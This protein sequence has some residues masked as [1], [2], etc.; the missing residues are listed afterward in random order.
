MKAKT[1][2]ILL[3]CKS[4]PW[5][6]KGGI[7]TH[8][9]E[10]SQSLVTLG[11][12]V[13]IL[14]GGAF[15][16]S[17][18]RFDKEGIQ[19][20]EL[21]FFPGRYVKPVSLLAEE[22]SFNLAARKW[23]K[24]HHSTFD[25]V[26]TQGRSG[27]LLY[28]L[29]DIRTKLIATVHGLIAR[30]SNNSRWYHF[31]ARLHALFSYK[32]EK[33]LIE[34]SRQCLAVSEDLKE[35][36]KA[37]Y[38][39]SKLKVVPNGVRFPVELPLKPKYTNGRFL[40]VGRLHPVKGLIPLVK[41]MEKAPP[42]IRLDVIGN[43]PQYVTLKRLIAKLN[44]EKRVRLLGEHSNEKVK[45]T[46]PF[47]QALVLP[48]QY[49]TQGIVLIEANAQGIPVIASDLPAIRESVIQGENGL[50]CPAHNP[51]SFI[52]AM[53]YMTDR[54]DEALHMGLA[55][56]KRVADHYSWDKIARQTIA[57]YHKLAG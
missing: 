34:A 25:V 3:I 7:Q 33:K 8:V 2:N 24:V 49:E 44:L 22:L 29:K 51:H 54:P 10:L 30:E 53:Q 19:V 42:H 11:H 48:S 16:A 32:I 36:L 40:F 4:L 35:D 55:G 27:Y 13:T 41:A 21:P 47:Y 28:T 14:T 17:E 38:D 50:L 26:H 43:G 23:V 18:Q 20:V 15:R 57:S 39:Q 52:D 45:E 6:F 1:L 9:W 56:R 37:Q 31:N 5:K 46:L 12:Q